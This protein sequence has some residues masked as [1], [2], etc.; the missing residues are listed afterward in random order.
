MAI[1]DST[2]NHVAT[3]IGLASSTE[4]C[5]HACGE[6]DLTDACCVLIAVTEIQMVEGGRLV[7]AVVRVGVESGYS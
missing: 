1:S 6:E 7:E 2:K 3:R 5:T 4:A